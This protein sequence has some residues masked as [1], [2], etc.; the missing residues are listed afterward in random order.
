MLAER[1]AQQLLRAQHVLERSQQCRQRNGQLGVVQQPA[2]I[3][4]RVRDALQEMWFAFIKSAKAIGAQG[5]HDANVNVGI[6]VPHECFAIQF[7]KSPKPFEIMMQQLL[8]QRRRQVGLGVVQKR[9]D[10][11]L[12]RAFASAL[13][14][15]EK[16]LPVAQHHVA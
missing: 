6:V 1:Q 13:V 14:I 10:V 4:E 12:Q 5:L 7:N 15:Q 3:L 11:V 16:R 2:Q 9:G 8:A